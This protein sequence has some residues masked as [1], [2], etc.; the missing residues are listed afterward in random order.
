M[1]VVPAVPVGEVVVADV[2]LDGW[3][4]VATEVVLV[5][6]GVVDPPLVKDVCSKHG[7]CSVH[8]R[9]EHCSSRGC[10]RVEGSHR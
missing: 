6:V 4:V 9:A 3:V 10:H 8:G 7:Q 2:T 1:G 5:A